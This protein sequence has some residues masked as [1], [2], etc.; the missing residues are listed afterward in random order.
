MEN[1]ANPIGEP[2]AP[3]SLAAARE[4]EISAFASRATNRRWHR[5]RARR[6]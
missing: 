4:A 3:A 5:D 2:E 1:I 6:I